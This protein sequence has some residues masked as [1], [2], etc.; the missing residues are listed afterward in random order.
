MDETYSFFAEDRTAPKLVAAQATGQ[1]TIR[2]GFDEDV[3]VVDPSG[4]EITPAALPAVPLALV[5]A[6]AVGTVVTA[7]EALVEED[8]S[9]L[10]QASG[11]LAYQD[12]V[13]SILGTERGPLT[14]HD[15][16]DVVAGNTPDIPRV[17]AKAKEL[18]M[19]RLARWLARRS[20]E[21]GPDS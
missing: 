16:P 11:A 17:E 8:P 4:F 18:A 3:V 15:A 10:E 20:P 14:R 5:S 9:Q 7:E 19:L 2:L 21:A 6:A 13:R 1:R 12:M